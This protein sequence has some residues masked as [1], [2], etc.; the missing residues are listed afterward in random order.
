MMKRKNT[1]KIPSEAIIDLS[2]DNS[3]SHSTGDVVVF[4]DH[5]VYARNTINNCGLLRMKTGVDITLS[6]EWY[7]KVIEAVL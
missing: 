7:S 2:K 4:L 3:V 6:N 1:I 5:I